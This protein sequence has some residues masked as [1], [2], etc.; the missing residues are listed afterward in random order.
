M[1]TALR[2]RLR[3]HRNELPPVNILW[4]VPDTSLRQTIAQF[5]EHV[6][7]VFPLETEHWGFED[8]SISIGG[9]ECLHY[10]EL[11]A[12]CKD[13]DEVIIKPLQF[14]EV[15][16]RVVTGRNQITGDG[17]HLVDGVPFGRP[18]VRGVTR[19]YLRIAPR[20]TRQTVY[21]A[22]D[23]LEEEECERSIASGEMLFDPSLANAMVRVEEEEDDEDDE[24]FTSLPDLDED[25]DLGLLDDIDA[26]LDGPSSSDSSDEEEEDS[27][28]EGSDSSAS[29]S[30][31]DSSDDSA[32]DDS[33]SD[34]SWDG[35]GSPKT[36]GPESVGPKSILS[37][38][39]AKPIASHA[40][41]NGTAPPDPNGVVPTQMNGLKRKRNDN[42][43]MTS[44]PAAVKPTNGLPNEGQQHTKERNARRRDQKQLRFLKHTGT[45]PPDASLVDLRAWTQGNR[46]HDAQ[47]MAIEMIKAGYYNVESGTA[48][49]ES[50]GEDHELGQWHANIRRARL[51]EA[52]GLNGVSSADAPKPSSSAPKAQ[53][54]AEKQE[55][56][57][58]QS[59]KLEE[60][61]QQLLDSI[62]EGGVDVEA[63][64]Q[65]RKSQSDRDADDDGPPEELSAKAGADGPYKSKP[66][67]TASVAGPHSTSKAA[68]ESIAPPK[69]MKAT[70]MVPASV[71]RRA[72]LDLDSSK[73]LLFGSLGVRVPK[74]EEDKDALRKKLAEKSQAKLKNGAAPIEAGKEISTSEQTAQKHDAE[75]W[76]KK[77]VLSAV[78]C[79]EE[80]ITLST[81]PFPF[82]QRWDPQQRRSKS[83]KRNAKQFTGS[84]K[85]SK[86]QSGASEGTFQEDYDKY[87]QN[88]EGDALDYDDAQDDEYWEDGAL[89]DSGMDDADAAAH[90]LLQETAD[91]AAEDFAPLPDDIATLPALVEAD[92]KPGDVIVYSELICSSATS[93]Q[94]I[95]VNRTIKLQDKYDAGWAVSMALRDMAAKEYDDDGERVYSKFEMEG[96]S[97]DDEEEEGREKIVEWASLGEVRLLTR[98]KGTGPASES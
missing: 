33:A 66:E 4:P 81:P 20:K 35:I 57:L 39:R 68:T 78:E 26:E 53:E 83:K 56:K 19:P 95:K 65:H 37:T 29:T 8:Y 59:A 25:E 7:T 41:T 14:A 58:K 32:S 54:K 22:V 91:Q 80:G 1:P 82:Y 17:R 52:N 42:D 13:E 38:A 64:S 72:K 27:S 18:M 75:A 47:R 62:A 9:F 21:D 48:P 77:I 40:L 88:G 36:T 46:P 15:R 70:D 34:H 84:V 86:T 11:G 44:A 16:A 97:D 28:S 73:R 51:A 85:R 94:P 5:L 45:L 74:T 93:W 31:R 60:Q 50:E 61:R 3:I 69:T 30:D 6:N 67:T 12:V 71:A 89:L 23:E 98:E 76:R 24:D 90:Q 92:A 10:H 43:E 79:C 55:K 87:N 96:L 2:L 63:R 49:G